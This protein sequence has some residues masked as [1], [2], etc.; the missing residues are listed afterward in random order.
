MRRRTI[1]ASV[2]VLACGAFL[3][4]LVASS[5]LAKVVQAQAKAVEPHTAG[6][7]VL[8][9]PRQPFKGKIVRKASE[10]APDFPKPLE[11]P[12]DAPNVL[13]IMTD[14]VGFAASSTFGG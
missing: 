14:D 6:G 13:L 4:W 3:G 11:A 9:R 2:A 10:S 7:D 1:F 12:K 8:P 5:R